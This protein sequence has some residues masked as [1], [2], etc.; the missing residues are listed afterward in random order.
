MDRGRITVN[1]SE[2]ELENDKI[3]NL[4][5]AYVN[6][7]LEAEIYEDYLIDLPADRR[8]VQVPVLVNQRKVVDMKYVLGRVLP[9]NEE[10]E[11]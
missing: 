6:R 1:D 7:V 2:L 3:H 4:L 5:H 8:K 11:D 9:T 10:A